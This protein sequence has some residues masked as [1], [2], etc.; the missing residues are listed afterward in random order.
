MK[1]FFNCEVKELLKDTTLISIAMVAENIPEY[2]G[3][4]VEPTF[5]AKNDGSDRLQ[6]EKW[7]KE[8]A[9]VDLIGK[10]DYDLTEV[11]WH[12]RVVGNIKKIRE[13][14][15]HWLVEKLLVD[16]KDPAV[17]IGD[18]LSYDWVLFC[19]LF[20][21]AS[22]VPCYISHDTHDINQ[23][24]ARVLDI[25]EKEAFDINRENFAGLERESKRDALW[26]AKVIKACYEK[27][28]KM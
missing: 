8:P 18:C 6:A 7:I 13:N 3:R 24:I 27:L 14:L 12:L 21:G 10:L 23:D 11:F 5:H 17:F 2:R 25:S 28:M 22:N 15:K 19:Q 20:H 1:V 16:N 4:I 26:G 9:I